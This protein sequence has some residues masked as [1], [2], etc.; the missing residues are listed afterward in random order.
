MQVLVIGISAWFGAFL[1]LTV[2]LVTLPFLKAMHNRGYPS[3]YST[4]VAHTQD[5]LLALL[6]TG[7]IFKEDCKWLRRCVKGRLE[8]A[9]LELMMMCARDGDFKGVE[10][11]LEKCIQEKK[12][13]NQN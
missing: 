10:R 2:L 7:N 3:I 8:V 13:Q 9:G 6:V 12:K 5:R 4:I 11:E 1:L